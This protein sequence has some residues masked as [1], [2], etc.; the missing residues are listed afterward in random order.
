M[1]GEVADADVVVTN[2]THVAVALK[3]NPEN[4]HAPV[5]VAMGERKVAE[6]IKEL[7]REASVPTV[8]NMPLARALLATA[9]V[10]RAIPMDLFVAVAELLAF[11]YRARG[12]GLPGYG[13]RA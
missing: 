5:V 8:E 13:A 11:V 6:R 4:A 1:L 9:E 12:A 2:P 7:A 10:G 3:Y